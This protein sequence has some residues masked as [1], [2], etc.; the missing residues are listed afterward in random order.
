MTSCKQQAGVNSEGA[1]RFVDMKLYCQTGWTA[2]SQTLMEA[3]HFAQNAYNSTAWNIEPYAVKVDTHG[4]TFC[5]APGSTQ[6]RIFY[7]A[8][9]TTMCSPC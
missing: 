8:E 2:T 9:W 4:N 6:V 1:L 3:L 5:R 7:N